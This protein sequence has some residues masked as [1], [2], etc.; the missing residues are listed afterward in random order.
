MVTSKL[1][2]EG[3]ITPNSVSELFNVQGNLE[4][5]KTLSTAVK[6]MNNIIVELVN[7]NKKLRQGIEHR[8]KNNKQTKGI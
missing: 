1:C 7:Q 4:T 3:V 6:A 2:Y 8:Q 5:I